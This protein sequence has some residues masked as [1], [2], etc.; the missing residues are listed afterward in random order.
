MLLRVGNKEK[1]TDLNLDLYM[2]K[3]GNLIE[4]QFDTKG[5]TRF[6]KQLNRSIR[7]VDRTVCGRCRPGRGLAG[8]THSGGREERREGKKWVKYI[9]SAFFLFL[10]CFLL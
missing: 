2:L 9:R 1:Q 4:V 7:S 5:N 3:Y 8:P 10:L 6:V